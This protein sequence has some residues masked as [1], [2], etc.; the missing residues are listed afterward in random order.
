MAKGGAAKGELVIAIFELANCFRHGWGIPKDPVAAKQVCPLTLTY[1]ENSY[2]HLRGLRLQNPYLRR[3]ILGSDYR[4][5]SQ[6][7]MLG[8][9]ARYSPVPP[10][11]LSR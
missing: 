5:I 3:T 8:I 7:R 11:Q 6:E 4:Q 1:H 9:L 2:D 10:Q